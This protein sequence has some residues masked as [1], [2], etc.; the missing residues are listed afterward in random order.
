MPGQNEGNEGNRSMM[1]LCEKLNVNADTPKAKL[2]ITFDILRLL[3]PKKF[4][5][6]NEETLKT[7][8]F[9]LAVESVIDSEVKGPTGFT[10]NNQLQKILDALRVFGSKPDPI[11]AEMKKQVELTNRI[12]ELRQEN[13]VSQ[14]KVISNLEFQIK[15]LKNR[16]KELVKYAERSDEMSVEIFEFQ[17]K[18]LLTNDQATA[19]ASALNDAINRAEEIGEKLEDGELKTK[20]LKSLDGSLPDKPNKTTYEDELEKLKAET[21]IMKAEKAEQLKK[22]MADWEKEGK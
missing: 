10:G 9:C 2:L 3:A 21:K 17:Q 22:L 7:T 15:V 14:K 8:E 5:E 11:I 20:L 16:F 12:L 4:L 1:T 6:M 19:L 18:T 13:D